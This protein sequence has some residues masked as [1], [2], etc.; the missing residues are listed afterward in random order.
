MIS[1]AKVIAG[2]PQDVTPGTKLDQGLV[3]ESE[4]LSWW[5][6]FIEYSDGE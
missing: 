6:E 5:Y 1:T 4:L 2:L 3:S